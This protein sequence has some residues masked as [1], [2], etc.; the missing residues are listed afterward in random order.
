M[1]LCRCGLYFDTKL[2][3]LFKEVFV[4]FLSEFKMF[5]RSYSW[6]FH[7]KITVILPMRR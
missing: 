1:V 3:V 5:W 6:L 2:A 4:G 7:V